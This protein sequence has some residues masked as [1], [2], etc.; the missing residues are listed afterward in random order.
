[1]HRG[2]WHGP[3]VLLISKRFLIMRVIRQAVLA[4]CCMLH[5][6]VAV[7]CMLHGFVACVGRINGASRA[8]VTALFIVNF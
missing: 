1:M 4:I 2:P 7:R 5:V 6:V 8:D 3:G